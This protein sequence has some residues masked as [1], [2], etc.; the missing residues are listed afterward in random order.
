MCGVDH[1]GKRAS[2]SKSAP[3]HLAATTAGL[4][5]VLSWGSPLLAHRCSNSTEKDLL[6][7]PVQSRLPALSS[8]AASHGRKMTW[9]GRSSAA[10][11]RS[12]LAQRRLAVPLGAE[13]AAASFAEL[14]P[15]IGG[16]VLLA[17]ASSGAQLSLAFSQPAAVGS[18]S[19]PEGSFFGP[20]RS[21]L[22]TA[23]I[24][25]AYFA[26]IGY[27]FMLAPGNTA[28]AKAADLT[29]IEQLL[30]KP[31]SSPIA[32]LFVGIFN[33]LGIWPAVYAATLLPG[34]ARQSP[35][36]A[37]PFLS[38]SFFA[39]AFGLTPY[40]ILREYRLKAEKEE[41]DWVT[42]Y[43]F[44]NRLAGGLLLLAGAYLALFGV[45]NGVIGAFALGEAWTAF[46][47]LFMSSQLAHVSCVDFMVLW[48]FYAPCLLEDGRRRNIFQGSPDEWPG[49][50]KALFL[51]CIGIPIFGG[52]A[53][54]MLRPPLPDASG[55]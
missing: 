13:E 35:V 49:S 37:W 54:L 26:L 21:P 29:I 44:E 24:A 8:R 20:A 7:L 10:Q 39:G 3:R 28:E 52:A 48:M 32:P 47:P 34:A 4:L 14:V 38:F 11:A 40:L 2:T 27:A 51:L 16:V 12:S 50:E 6:F 33:S 18:D 23:G 19:N 41:L 15:Y 1:P 31:F 30:D 43:L 45:G 46:L 42:Q 36:P 5:C 53:W 25:L 55:R 9:A 17:A 22:R